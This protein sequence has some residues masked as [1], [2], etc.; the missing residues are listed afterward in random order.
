MLEKIKWVEI[1]LLSKEIYFF[2][3]TRIS[4]LYHYSVNKL[5][6]IDANFN[7]YITNYITKQYQK[8]CALKTAVEKRHGERM[9]RLPRTYG[10]RND[11]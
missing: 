4:V 6:A 7:I 2:L 3:Y 9:S 10:A 5:T 8:F 11:D 1:S